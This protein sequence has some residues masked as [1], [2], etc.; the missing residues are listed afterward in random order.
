MRLHLVLDTS[1]PEAR[2]APMSKALR[3]SLLGQVARLL[4]TIKD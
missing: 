2:T 1:E 4:Q 3:K